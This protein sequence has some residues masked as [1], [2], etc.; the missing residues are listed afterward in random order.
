MRS[1]ELINLSLFVVLGDNIAYMYND[2][3]TA[4][5]GKFKNGLLVRSSYS[6]SAVLLVIAKPN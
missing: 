3:K 6:V 2:I 5:V 1:Y 4:I